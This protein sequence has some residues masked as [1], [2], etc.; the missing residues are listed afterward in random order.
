[1][2][3]WM[4]VAGA[5]ALWRFVLRPKWSTNLPPG[6]MGWPLLGEFISFYFRPDEFIAQRRQKYGN[7]FKTCLFGYPIIIST[8]PHVSN[9]ILENDGQLFVPQFPTSLGE[10]FGKSNIMQSRGD[11][12]KKKRGVYMR[13]VGI[14]V[15]K[16]R[17]LSAIQNTIMSTLSGWRGRNVNVTH[18]VEEMIFSLMANHLLSLKPGTQLEKMKRDFYVMKKGFVSLALNVPGT[19]FHK[20]LQKRE[21]LSDQIKSIIKERKKSM[22]SHDSSDDLLSS[23]LKDAEEKEDGDFEISTFQ[24]VDFILSLMFVV[25]ETTPKTITLAVKRLSENPHIIQELRAEYEAIRH[26]K[27]NNETLSWDDYK[28]M[29]FT[30]NVITEMLRLGTGHINSMLMRKTV[31]NV[32]IQGY[33]IPKGWTCMIF[34]EVSSLDSNYYEDPLAFNPRRWQDPA[35]NHTPSF[36]F[37]GGPRKCPGYEFATLFISLFLHHLVTNFRWDYIPSDTKLR[38]FDSPFQFRVDCIVRLE[39]FGN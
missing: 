9:F 14:P 8:D 11:C 39:D 7:L 37:G 22:S 20:S 25:L 24:I 18:E 12:H 30:K 31:E 5:L 19:S 21:E 10:L 4:L 28:S 35:I 36:L 1:M 3:I 16:G 13:V 29:S 2:M 34:H 15:L 32:E 33:T 23:M 26:T 38:W 27:G 17:L 6:T